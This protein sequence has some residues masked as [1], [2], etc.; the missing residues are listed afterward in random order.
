MAKKIVKQKLIESENQLKSYRQTLQSCYG[1]QL[2]LH[3]YSVVA[4]G[5]ER[6]IHCEIK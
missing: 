4:V 3:S 1:N 2:R 6:L 5:Y